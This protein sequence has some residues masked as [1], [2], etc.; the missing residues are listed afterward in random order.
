MDLE[1]RAK[2]AV[3]TGASRGI[4]RAIATALAQEGCTVVLAA[5]SEPDLTAAAESIAARHADASLILEPG[6]LSR[7]EVQ[8][9]LIER[10]GDAEVLVNNAGA[11]PHGDLLGLDDAAWVHGWELKVFG[12]IR[13]TRGFYAAMK[14]RG[15][16]VI[17][18]VIGAAGERVMPSYIAGSTGNA[19]LIAFTR[20]VGTASPGDNIRVVGVSPGPIETERLV[21][22]LEGRAAAELG[23]ARR[24]RELAAHMPFG[25]PGHPQEVADTV[26]FLASPRAGFITGSIVNVDGGMAQRPVPT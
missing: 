23:D 5:R 9:A 3:V 4:G 20:A 19:A 11:I 2:K 26:A 24:W 17:V 13:L 18:N 8:A 1:L 22:R 6:D 21:R 12:Q 10:H 14:A 7:P 25:R 16:G 15:G